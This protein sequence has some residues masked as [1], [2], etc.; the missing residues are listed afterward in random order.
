MSDQP[1]RANKQ[2]NRAMAS[3][4][5]H[6]AGVLSDIYSWMFGGFDNGVEQN[7]QFFNRHRLSPRGSR[8]AIDLGAGCGFQSIPLARLGYAV[9]AIDMDKKLLSE[10]QRN[11]KDLAINVVQDD[12]LNFG[13]SVVNDAELIICMTDTLTHLESKAQVASLLVKVYNSLESQGKFITTFRDLTPE[14]KDTDRVF[15]VKSD[16]Q[17]IF[18]CFLEYEKETVKIHDLVYQKTGTDW[19]LFKSFYR[20]L[21]IN[22]EWTLNELSRSGFKDI[23]ST[24]DNG[25]ITIIATK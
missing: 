2:E 1:F 6:Y 21:R 11:A 22:A 4:Q 15:P 8:I 9:V 19:Q 13:E 20:K 5:E 7:I 3:V 10:L 17:R 18:T 25:F 23:D 16:E 24:E 14:L 12:L